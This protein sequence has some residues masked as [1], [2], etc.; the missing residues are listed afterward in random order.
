[1]A[2][3]D[4]LREAAYT[5]PSGKRTVFLYEDVSRQIDRKTSAYD[6]PDADGTYIQDLGSSGRRYPIPAIFSGPDCDLD[7]DA[8]EADLLERGTGRL[9]HPVYGAVDVVPFG[10]ITRKDN[11][12]T[13][14]N[15]SI[16]EVVF[17]QTIGVIYP[18]AQADKASA[19]LASIEEFNEASAA[20]FE[21]SVR[22]ETMVEKAN[23]KG[24]FLAAVAGVQA[25]LGRVADTQANV[26]AQF[27]T[28]VASINIGID[29]LIADPLTLAFQ[30]AILVQAPARAISDIRARLNAYGDL[31]HDIVTSAGTVAPNTFH[32]RDLCASAYV[33]GSILAVVNN[34]F[35]T[36]REA[37]EAAETILAQFKE[38]SDWRDPNYIGI[39]TGEAYQALQVAV[40]I[41]TGYLV[42]ISFT[43]KQERTITLDRD[44]T[45]IDLAAELYG[46]VDSELD[47]LINTNNLT[48]SEILELPR[49]RKIVYYR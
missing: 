45:I 14:A 30:T 34:R 40:A 15:E 39:D 20:Q 35:T 25:G 9:E 3:S 27:N 42:E 21:A 26:R 31:L 29:L 33:T 17:W 32:R 2:W 6:F 49:G 10:T 5:S 36:K 46:A 24:P 8:F 38:L 41:A 11:L 12:K 22:L 37:L 43:L 44:R 19:V 28:M 1:M 18:A 23:F 16:V 47:F 48:G 4:R 13:G 7:A